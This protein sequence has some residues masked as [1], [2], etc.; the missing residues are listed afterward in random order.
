V[1]GLLL[2]AL[3]TAS[4]ALAQVESS[5]PPPPRPYV[6]EP[7]PGAAEGVFIEP[8]IG[9][10]PTEEGVFGPGE[11]VFLGPEIGFVQEDGT[12]SLEQGSPPPPR[13]VPEGGAAAPEEGAAVQPD[14]GFVQEDGTIS[15][16]QEAAAPPPAREVTAATRSTGALLRSLDKVTG[17]VLDLPLAEGE[18]ARLGSVS[19]ALGECRYP[20]DD[21]ASDG[22][23]WVTVLDDT[24]A[25][26]A[27]QGWLIASAPA[28]SALDHPR[29]DVWLIRCNIPEAEPAPEAEEPEEPE[30]IPEEG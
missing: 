15:L 22:F 13:P 7:N 8:E 27:F 3:L 28:L 16:E 14:I 21:P 26:P 11:S 10:A 5:S 19:V 30:I 29:Y 12:L 1:R 25:E 2:A 17:A 6:L 4:P 9:L 18:T 24:L 23:A 20:T